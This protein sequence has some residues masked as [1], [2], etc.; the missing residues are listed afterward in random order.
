MDYTERNALA[1]AIEER[2]ELVYPRNVFIE[3][4]EE[5]FAEINALLQRE[6]GHQLDGIAAECYRRAYASV[7]LFVREYDD[8]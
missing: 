5:Q 2:A 1:D 8:A 7:A 3:P 6:R 4:T